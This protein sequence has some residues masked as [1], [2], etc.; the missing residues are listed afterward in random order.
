[1]WSRLRTAV[2]MVI[3][4]IESCTRNIIL[5][6]HCKDAAIDKSEL[7]IKQIDLAGKK[8]FA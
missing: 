8:L 5:V 7:T 6:C 1:M 2:E 3:D 4:K